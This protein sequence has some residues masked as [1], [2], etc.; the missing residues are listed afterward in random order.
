MRKLKRAAHNKNSRQAGVF[1]HRYALINGMAEVFIFLF[2]F[3]D[4]L[5]FLRRVAKRLLSVA[6][7]VPARSVTHKKTLARA[8]SYTFQDAN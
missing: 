7:F 1:A 5:L 2:V 4:R 8:D 6:G 3:L